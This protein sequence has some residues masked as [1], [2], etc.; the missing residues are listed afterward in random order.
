MSIFVSLKETRRDLFCFFFFFFFYWTVGSSFHLLF[1]PRPPC[2]C[3]FISKRRGGIPTGNHRFQTAHA[4][5]L[6]NFVPGRATTHMYAHTGYSIR[7]LEF[8]LSVCPSVWLSLYIYVRKTPAEK[9]KNMPCLSWPETH[10]FFLK[11]PFQTRKYAAIKIPNLA[12]P[13]T[14]TMDPIHYQGNFLSFWKCLR[15]CSF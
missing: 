12:S 6:H 11:P 13:D 14:T 1:L 9:Q 2:F 5:H 3:R 8:L 4:Y 15:C 7:S 10:K